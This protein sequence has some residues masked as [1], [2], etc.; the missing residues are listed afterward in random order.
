KNIQKQSEVQAEEWE[1][2]RKGNADKNDGGEVVAERD[3]RIAACREI[4]TEAEMNAR[5]DAV[6][7]PLSS[8]CYPFF[9]SK[10]VQ[11]YTIILI[12]AV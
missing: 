10:E 9:A 7:C 2:E 4:A 12:F 6:L 1:E 3:E 11:R 5:K 8:P